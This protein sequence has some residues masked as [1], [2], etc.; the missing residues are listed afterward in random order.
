MLLAL[1]H[2]AAAYAET[3]IRALYGLNRSVEILV[4]LTAAHEQHRVGHVG[5][6]RALKAAE[7]GRDRVVDHMH[8][9][10]RHTGI[11]PQQVVACAL[12]DAHYGVGAAYRPALHIFVQLR[13]HEHKAVAETFH[14][15]V[16][17]GQDGFRLFAVRQT[18]IG[19]VKYA[20]VLAVE[21]C[22]QHALQ[23]HRQ[24]ACFAFEQQM[25]G[26]CDSLEVVHGVR[27]FKYSECFQIR[28]HV[29]KHVTPDTRDAS[30][31]LER[32]DDVVEN[33]GFQSSR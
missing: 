4:A 15:K 24:L 10:G 11:E 33:Y 28:R 27:I 1:V 29:C 20:F 8:F 9:A 31:A 19:G 17:Y 26:E 23:C 16:V 25:V 2:G 18:V 7:L 13:A 22:R 12:A 21:T 30:R 6:W 3:Q 32:K 5:V 14:R